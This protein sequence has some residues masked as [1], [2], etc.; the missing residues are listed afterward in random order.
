MMI[1]IEI[2]IILWMKIKKKWEN[3]R[4]KYNHIS[5]GTLH[6]S[7]LSLWNILELSGILSPTAYDFDGFVFLICAARN[8]FHILFRLWS[9]FNYLI[10][11]F[12]T[13]RKS[14]KASSSLR[15]RLSRFFI[16][17]IR[18]KTFKCYLSPIVTCLVV[19]WLIWKES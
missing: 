5:I 16:T 9:C 13:Y 17:S 11:S 3:A 10:D 18:K 19:L 2:R 12:T 4:I 8:I 14:L 7:I 15:R 1:S 6:V